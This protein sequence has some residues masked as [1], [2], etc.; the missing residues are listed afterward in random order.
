MLPENN[1]LFVT[2]QKK[3]ELFVSCYF[4]SPSISPDEAVSQLAREGWEVLSKH[5][6]DLRWENMSDIFINF[7]RRHSLMETMKLS[8]SYYLQGVATTVVNYEKMYLMKHNASL[9]HEEIVRVSFDESCRA[10]HISNL[11]L[12][13][14]MFSNFFF[15]KGVEAAF[16]AGYGA[17]MPYTQN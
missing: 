2:A 10:S 9:S 4:F 17:M 16:N 13:E 8:A 7:A 11:S 15:S 6:I 12:E 1:F 14:N 3:A 5:A